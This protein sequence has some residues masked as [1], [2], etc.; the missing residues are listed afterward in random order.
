[1]CSFPVIILTF[2]FPKY[3]QLQIAPLQIKTHGAIWSTTT[4]ISEGSHTTFVKRPVASGSSNKQTRSIIRQSNLSQVQKLKPVLK[5][6]AILF[7]HNRKP[8]FR[9]NRRVCRWIRRAI[10]SE[11]R[12]IGPG[13]SLCSIRGGIDSLRYWGEPP[14]FYQYLLGQE[15]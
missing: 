2:S 3:H 13:R 1:M 9:S 5:V 11:G 15:I 8:L 12:A 7:K 6:R 14:L 4:Q 10:R